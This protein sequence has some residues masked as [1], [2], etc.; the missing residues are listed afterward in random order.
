MAG[1]YQEHIF[2]R[3]LLPRPRHQLYQRKKRQEIS[4]ETKKK[5]NIHNRLASR[6][7]RPKPKLGETTN[8]RQRLEMEKHTASLADDFNQRLSN[9]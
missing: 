3:K 9:R 4:Q 8:Y 1:V 5:P 7:A 2:L 6:S